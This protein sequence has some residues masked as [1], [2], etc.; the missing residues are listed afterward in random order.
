MWHDSFICDMTQLCDVTDLNVPW[1]TTHLY[2]T[3]LIHMWHDSTVWHDWIKCAGDIRPSQYLPLWWW[4]R[5]LLWPNDNVFCCY[6]YM[7]SVTYI[8]RGTRECVC[9]CV[10]E[11]VWVCVCVC[12]CISAA[13]HAFKVLTPSHM[14]WLRLVGSFN[15][16]SLL[17][18]SFVGLFCKIVGLFCKRA[19]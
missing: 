10:C 2:V 19:L 4:E 1:L 6:L 7:S 14:G 3:W 9:A 11:C 16:R 18:K 12:A 17:Q 13:A 15:C 8:C 5:V